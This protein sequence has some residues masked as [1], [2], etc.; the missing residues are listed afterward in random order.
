MRT[1]I[2]PFLVLATAFGLTACGL[3]VKPADPNALL[4]TSDRPPPGP[5]LFTGEDGVFKIVID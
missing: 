5:G 1:V 3:Q 2:I 4:P